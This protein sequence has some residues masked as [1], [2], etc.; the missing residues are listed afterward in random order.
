MGKRKF[1]PVHAG[2]TLAE[3]FLKP[4]AITQYRL[5]NEGNFRRNVALLYAENNGNLFV[6][7][8]QL[9]MIAVY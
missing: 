3:D 9:G 1:P 7:A 4:M 2:V 8:R 6:A 5:G